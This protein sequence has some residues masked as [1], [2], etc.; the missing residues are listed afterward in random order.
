[1]HHEFEQLNA[2]AFTSVRENLDLRRRLD[3]MSRYFYD[4]SIKNRK[5]S[6]VTKSS[7]SL[8]SKT[9]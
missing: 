2:E 1:M 3:V 5:Q 4:D 9:Y 7:V 8:I 6:S